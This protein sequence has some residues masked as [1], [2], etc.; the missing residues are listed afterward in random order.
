MSRADTYLGTF[1]TE[2][3]SDVF[4]DIR[5]AIRGSEPAPLFRPVD[6]GKSTSLSET[7]GNAEGREGDPGLPIA[8]RRQAPGRPLS[9]D[10]VVF[11]NLLAERGVKI[12]CTCGFLCE[13]SRSVV[14]R[15][16]HWQEYGLAAPDEHATVRF[17]RCRRRVSRW[18]GSTVG[19]SLLP[20]SVSTTHA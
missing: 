17:R 11:Y 14:T 1:E 13:L 6:S 5:P 19:R 3:Q 12:Q 4:Q 15:T 18:L 20:M 7:N 9:S 10:N 16:G 2:Q 8:R